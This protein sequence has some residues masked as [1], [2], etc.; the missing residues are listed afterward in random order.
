MERKKRKKDKMAKGENKKKQNTM[1][2][3]KNNDDLDDGIIED[4][5]QENSLPV[6]VMVQEGVKALSKIL[7]S[8][9]Q[10]DDDLSENTMKLLYSGIEDF[11]NE[12]KNETNNN[13]LIPSDGAILD[14][15][16]DFQDI[17]FEINTNM[18]NG[19]DSE[20]LNG[21]EEAEIVFDYG[22]ELMADSPQDIGERIS[23]MLESVL[24]NGFQPGSYGKLHAVLN[25]NELNITEERDDDQ[26][27]TNSTI[28]NGDN[29]INLELKTQLSENL[30]E[31]E[32][33]N[34][35]HFEML[36]QQLAEGIGEMHLHN[37]EH[38]PNK[39]DNDKHHHH[40]HHHHH[41]QAEH[42]H[43]NS[44]NLDN[45]YIHSKNKNS[46]YHDHQYSDCDVSDPHSKD[47]KPDFSILMNEDQAPM[48]MFCEYY[49]V[50]G[51]PPRNMIKWYNLNYGTHNHDR[52]PT[53]NN[54]R[55]RNR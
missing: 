9:L 30:R 23:Q 35:R 19:D 18:H 40:H 38:L 37:Q 7:S 39:E 8:H 28:H 46:L 24:P 17:E 1:P 52:Q 25:G 20:L 10:N 4:I 51:K 29:K 47:R 12:S 33:E 36:S 13:A 16:N 49:M 48:C 44:Q 32:K 2:V 14:D 42:A 41:Q 3:E 31:L 34:S 27:L 55:K 50:F 11:Q 26:H 5:T 45:H 6:N 54:R 21:S 53:S 22:S 43:H 15:D